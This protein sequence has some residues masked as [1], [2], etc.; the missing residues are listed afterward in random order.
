MY[1]LKKVFDMQTIGIRALRT[2]PGLLSRN[3]KKGLLTLV[4][5]HSMPVSL[6]VPFDDTLLSLGIH[7]LLAIKLFEEGEI[8]LKRAAK[9]ADLSTEAFLNRLSI[10][11]I[12]VVDQT[13]DELDSELG[14]F[15]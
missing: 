2:N 11:G 4:T 15:E 6:S 9:L 5:S 3:A 13:A 12:V 14:H 10:L 7:V 8:T 1:K